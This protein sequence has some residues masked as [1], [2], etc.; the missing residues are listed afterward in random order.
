[1]Q[2]RRSKLPVWRN[3][4]FF[5]SKHCR[6]CGVGKVR[7]IRL[8]NYAFFFTPNIVQL[9][10]GVKRMRQ[11]VGKIHMHLSLLTISVLWMSLVLVRWVRQQDTC[12]S[13]YTLPH[14]SSLVSSTFP[15][16][17]GPWKWISELQTIKTT[18]W[19]SLY[20]NSYIYV[21]LRHLDK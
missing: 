5:Y 3:M 6:L 18:V 2:G 14:W 15:S 9:F 12:N 19:W 17:R 11:S 20:A 10:R 16:V 1:M 8:L 13:M 7:V 4:L 21:D